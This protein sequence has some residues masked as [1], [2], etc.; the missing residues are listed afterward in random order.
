MAVITLEFSKKVSDGPA[1][2]LP[3]VSQKM[4]LGYWKCK[5]NSCRNFNNQVSFFVGH[6]IFTFTFE[7]R[8]DSWRITGK[9]KYDF[10]G[11]EKNLI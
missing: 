8:E 6:G 4:I 7:V 11:L 9:K 5:S 3:C 10:F 2:N 1:Y